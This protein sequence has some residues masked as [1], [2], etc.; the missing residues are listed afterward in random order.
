MLS[1]DRLNM[2]LDTQS[3][4]LMLKLLGVDNQEQLSATM[5]AVSKRALNRNMERVKEVY[6]QLQMEGGG[7][8]TIELESVSVRL[9]KTEEYVGKIVLNLIRKCVGKIL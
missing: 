8:N 6:I 3:L 4:D 1:R 2:D 9:Y 7:M 5:T